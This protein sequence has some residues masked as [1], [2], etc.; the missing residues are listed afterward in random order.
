[1]VVKDTL[2]YNILVR[3][4]EGIFEAKN[5]L[6]YINIFYVNRLHGFQHFSVI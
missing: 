3:K 1:M 2:K 6:L 5:Q 4:N